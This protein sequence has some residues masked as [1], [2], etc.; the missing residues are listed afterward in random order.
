MRRPKL[1]YLTKAMPKAHIIG[2]KFLEGF[3]KEGNREM[4]EGLD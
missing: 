2:Y 3:P 4:T 1:A